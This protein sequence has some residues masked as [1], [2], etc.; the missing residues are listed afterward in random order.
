MYKRTVSLLSLA[1]LGW[2]HQAAAQ[3]CESTGERHAVRIEPSPADASVNPV[4]Y[5]KNRFT[6][7]LDNG[8]TFALL[9]SEYGWNL[10]LTDK[11]RDAPGSVDMSAITPPYGSVPANPRDIAGWHFRNAD[12]TGPNT[13]DVN[14]PQDL[15]VFMFDEALIGTGGFR[16]PRD[17]GGLLREPPGDTGR[18]W[19]LIKEYG[20]T[21]LKEGE[22]A[23]MVYMEFA[24]CL[25]WP[26]SED[27]KREGD[28]A[29]SPVYIAEELESIARC[30]LDLEN[31]TLDARF[32]PRQL[33]GDFDGDGAGDQ[34]V[35]ITRKSDGRAG[36]AV[37]R[38]S[39]WLNAIGIEQPIATAAVADY[40]PATEAWTVVPAG[41]SPDEYEYLDSSAWP[42]AEGDV[43]VL[44]RLEKQAVAVFWKDGQLQTKELFHL[45]TE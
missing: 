26:K 34:I 21:D 20:L 3:T 33:G 7:T 31:Y 35:Q 18:G 4:V 38:A 45:V 41:A 19:L 22:K 30:G 29:S 16:P 37:C 28:D 5:G 32:L 39:T 42:N 36:L 2:T 9:P 14:A 10:Q 40:L 15:R 13:G 24:A 12:N 1:I 17:S 43:V 11:P 8:W 6:Q 27:E 23:R 25:T 44:Q